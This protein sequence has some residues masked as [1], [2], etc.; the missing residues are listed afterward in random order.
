[1]AETNMSDT[2]VAG[3]L[4]ETVTMTCVVTSYPAPTFSWIRGNN[5][6]GSLGRIMSQQDSVISDNLFKSTLTIASVKK[7]N[8]VLVSEGIRR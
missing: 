4:L 5:V 3:D 7:G 8:S 6:L 1:M 2:R